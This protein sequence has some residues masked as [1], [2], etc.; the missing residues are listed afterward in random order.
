MT[1]KDVSVLVDNEEYEGDV[2]ENADL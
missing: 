2:L 1:F